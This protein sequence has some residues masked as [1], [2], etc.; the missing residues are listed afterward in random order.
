MLRL[1]FLDIQV[2]RIRTGKHL[3]M[4]TSVR[5]HHASRAPTQEALMHLYSVSLIWRHAHDCD[6]TLMIV[7][8]Q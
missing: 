6:V 2:N 4:I 5:S 8:S 3:F 1:L 7:T